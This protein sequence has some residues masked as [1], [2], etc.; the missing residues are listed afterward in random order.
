MIPGVFAPDVIVLSQKS[1][2]EPNQKG[3]S[4]LLA[5]SP[6]SEWGLRFSWLTYRRGDL[7]V[8]RLFEFNRI[9]SSSSA[10]RFI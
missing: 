7:Y 4:H 9:E 3:F 2:H 6:G 1:V 5:F 8:R 10:R